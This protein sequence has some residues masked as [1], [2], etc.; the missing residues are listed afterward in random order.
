M[1]CLSIDVPVEVF[2]F[3]RGGAP[4]KPFEWTYNLFW[5]LTEEAAVEVDM[6]NQV[7]TNKKVGAMWPNNAPG[8][9]YRMMYGGEGTGWPDKSYTYVDPGLYNE[10]SE[11]FS[12]QI[13]CSSRKAARSSRA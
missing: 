4:D 6:F 5:G 8:N 7:V 9:A 2:V 3:Q 11:E 12:P 10:P 13:A 1:P